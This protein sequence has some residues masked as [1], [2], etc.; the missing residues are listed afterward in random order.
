MATGTSCTKMR[1]SF[2]NGPKN[3]HA[4]FHVRTGAVIAA[5]VGLGVAAALGLALLLSACGAGTPPMPRTGASCMADLNKAGAVFS[6]WSAPGGACSVEMPLFLE[7]AGPALRPPVKTSCAMATAWADFTAQI[8]RIA[9]EQTGSPV[10]SVLTAGSWSCRSMTGNARRPSLH[11]S[12]RAID[13]VG[14]VLA[15]GQRIM[16]KRD[17]YAGNASGRFLRKLGKAA[18]RHFQVVLGPPA[19][20]FHHDHLHVD[21]GPWKLCQVG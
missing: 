17:W 20:R 18:C 2:V 13:L 1:E 9:R 19:D 14:F 3:T 10:A 12:G 16:V 4:D 6:P 15:D 21:I 8:D 11:A 5:R 7:R